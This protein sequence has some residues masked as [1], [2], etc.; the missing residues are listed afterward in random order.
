MSFI[1]RGNVKIPIGKL[2][3]G[4]FSYVI[5]SYFECLL[6]RIRREIRLDGTL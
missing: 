4:E 2:G 3:I 5:M 6:M 1:T